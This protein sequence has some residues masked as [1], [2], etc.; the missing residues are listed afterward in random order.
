M[1]SLP[2]TSRTVFLPET[3]GENLSL[4]LFLLL[5]ATWV[6]WLVAPSSSLTASRVS[7]SVAD[8]ASVNGF[9]FCLL[10][11]IL[12]CPSLIRTFV[13]PLGLSRKFRISPHPDPSFSGD[14]IGEEIK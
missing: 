8:S 12:L 2:G 14:G 5:E 6:P 11:Q 4:C 10:G 9:L 13:I 1:V 7:S 3:S